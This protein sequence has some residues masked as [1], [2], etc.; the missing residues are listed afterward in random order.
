MTRSNTSLNSHSILDN[1]THPVFV[2]NQKGSINFLNKAAQQLLIAN[3]K[4]NEQDKPYLELCPAMQNLANEEADICKQGIQAVLAKQRHTFQFDY[5]LDDM[6]WHRMEASSLDDSSEVLICH[7]DISELKQA[8]HRAE[9]LL[10]SPL[11]A[12]LLINTAGY[13]QLINSKLE[14]LFGYSQ[15]ELFG[16]GLELLIPHRFR[17]Q[18]KGHLE[19]YFANPSMRPMGI[20]LELFALARDGREFPV[21]ISLNPIHSGN[22]LLVS[23]AIRDISKI[24]EDEAE[25]NRLGRI[26]ESS[27]NEIYLF[28]AETLCFVYANQSALANLG[29]GKEEL[30]ELTPLDVLHDYSFKALDD[31]LKPLK[32]GTKDR[33]NLDLTVYR[34]DVS[35][36]PAA[37]TLQYF[38]QASPPVFMASAIDI[39]E[40]ERVSKALQESQ[41]RMNEHLQNTPLAVI[42]WRVNDHII[43]TWNPASERL[44]GYNADEVIEKARADIIIS[45]EDKVQ[46]EPFLNGRFENDGKR[47][48]NRNITKDGRILIFEWYN[49]VIKNEAGTVISVAALGLDVTSRQQALEAL[50]SAQEEE[51]ARISRDLHDQVGQSLTGLILG[52][53]HAKANNLDTTKFKTLAEMILA[54]V[55]RISRD[56][57]P[58]LLDELGLVPAL[59]RLTR[60]IAEYA[61]VEIDTLLQVPDKLTKDQQT[62][63]YRVVQ[64]GLTNVVRHAN[65][66]HASVTLTN[67]TSFTQLVIED[68][69]EGFDPN[70]V[71][72]NKHFG[73]ASMR[74]RVELVSGKLSIDS[75][76][77]QGTT[78]TVRFKH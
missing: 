53:S 68:N 1:L 61:H 46:L 65:A 47:S 23:A 7:N 25:L 19:K 66:S 11:D 16:Q 78:L 75:S 37:A 12:M 38:T 76:L 49:T 3:G 54:D 70:L 13:I 35:S 45:K 5:Q 30:F 27:A 20:N 28:D 73:L 59:K 62:V 8:E 74:E 39:S 40:Q 29:Y 58:P 4:Q 22:S 42:E 57:R 34:K 15:D 77:K 24:K 31:L 48:N 51:R 52:L 72:Q 26:L 33:L 18:H 41:E 2:L 71:A 56:L 64:E 9:L 60:D 14:K 43:T 69:G 50:L 63:I 44:F 21:E 32:V 10:E 67:Q 36:Y 55:R 6:T 17:R